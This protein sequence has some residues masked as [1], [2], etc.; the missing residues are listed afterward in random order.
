MPITRKPFVPKVQDPGV[1]NVA[2]PSEPTTQNTNQYDSMLALFEEQSRKIDE[3]NRR[4]SELTKAQKASN[5]DISED[6]KNAQRKYGYDAGNN[7]IPE[8][9]FSFKYRVLM[10]DRKERVVI[11]ANTVGRPVNF[12]NENTGKWTNVHMVEI[13]FHDGTKAEI[14]VLDYVNQFY[15]VEESIPDTDIERKDG[16]TYY[17]FRTEKFGTF[18]VEQPFVN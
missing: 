2:L 16:K 18:K 15:L 6:I 10:H 11:S 5:G 1:Q 4:I 3:Q 13:T 12:R 14:D 9:Q 17:T 7:R 8:E